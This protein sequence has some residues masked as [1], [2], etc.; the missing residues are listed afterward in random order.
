[1][2]TS[3]VI[4]TDSEFKEFKPFNAWFFVRAAGYLIF[5]QTFAVTSAIVCWY[6]RTVTKISTVVAQS[7][8]LADQSVVQQRQIDMLTASCAANKKL[9]IGGQ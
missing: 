6:P 1:M 8:V 3:R 2:K 5:V 7:W 9:G 4:L